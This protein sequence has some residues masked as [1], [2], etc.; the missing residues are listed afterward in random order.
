MC[1]LYPLIFNIFL[2]T[3]F[4][5]TVTLNELSDT[6]QQFIKY[7]SLLQNVEKMKEGKWDKY[8]LS[9]VF[10]HLCDLA[11]FW[12]SRDS[13]V[14]NMSLSLLQD[15]K[16]GLSQDMVNDYCKKLTDFVNAAMEFYSPVS[17]CI[18]LKI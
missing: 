4:G 11:D 1:I 10:V 12:K 16:S 6:T 7:A 2:S 17:I 9:A 13:S 3:V 18:M 14:W 8:V 15:T 5:S